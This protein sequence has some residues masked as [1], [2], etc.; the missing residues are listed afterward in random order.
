MTYA[1]SNS[2]HVKLQVITKNIDWL[3][4]LRVGNENDLDK[5][6]YEEENLPEVVKTWTALVLNYQVALAPV[7]LL[8]VVFLRVGWHDLVIINLEKEL[9]EVFVAIPIRMDIREVSN[10]KLLGSELFAAYPSL[11]YGFM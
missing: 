9:H 5:E 10:G 2:T 6:G 8:L 4:D 3:T 11:K 1:Y 7:S